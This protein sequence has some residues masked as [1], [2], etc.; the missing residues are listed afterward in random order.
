MGVEECWR[1]CC[2]WL[3]KIRLIRDDHL[4][5]SPNA[6]LIDLCKFLRDGVMICKILHILDEDSIDLRTINQR[7]Q[8][9]QFLCMKNIGIF[10]QTCTRKFD[11]N[12]E[13]LFE[14]PMLFE[15]SDIGK[16]LHTLSRLSKSA[17]AQRLEVEG[18]PAEQDGRDDDDIY[19]ELPRDIMN[20]NVETSNASPM[21]SNENDVVRYG[22][23]HTALG[24]PLRRR[25]NS[26][27]AVYESLCYVTLKPKEVVPVNKPREKRDLC[28]EE[29]VETEHN[30]VDA[31]EMLTNQFYRPLREVIGEE[32]CKRIF[33]TIPKM[34]RIHKILHQGL[35]KAQN[36]PANYSVS[37]V[38][39]TNQEE[40]LIY[41]EY[42]ANLSIAQQEL[43]D[44]MNNNDSAKN[45]IQELQNNVKEGKHQLREYLLVPLQR[46]LKYHLLL[47]ELIRSTSQTHSDHDNLQRA[48]EAMM[49]LSDFI[50]EVKR[51]S[52]MKQIIKDLQ[53]SIMD[54]PSEISNMEDLGKLRHDGDIRIECHPHPIKKRY[55]FVFD[56]VMIMCKQTKRISQLFANN[57]P[58][59]WSLG[60]STTEDEKYVFKDWV[61]LDCCKVDNNV[62]GGG[63]ITKN[64]QNSFYLVLGENKAAYT[65]ITKDSDAK[66]KWMKSISEAIEFLN[67]PENLSLHHVFIV[68]TFPRPNTRC[69]K[70]NKLLKGSIFQG[71]QCANCKMIVHKNC[72]GE[73]TRC[74]GCPPPPLIDRGP[75]N[76]VYPGYLNLLLEY[77]WWAD[78][79]SRDNAEHLLSK[80]EE[81]TFL[82]RWSD[83]HRKPVLSLRA[84]GETKHM[85]VHY[86]MESN[87]FFLSEAHYFSSIPDLI[88]FH[89]YSPLSESFIGLDC[90]LRRP[91]YD[92]A[93]VQYPYEGSSRTY[94]S[95]ME[96]ERVIILSREGE[97]RGWWKGRIGNR[98]GYF[99]KEYV[100]TDPIM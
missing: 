2:E 6:Q 80:A 27:E 37:Q 85:K 18:F 50:N 21:A 68:T 10:L 28:L 94:L 77:P 96:G 15:L 92:T 3:S 41:G 97:S 72:L 57:N 46:I 4:L 23:D 11:L 100:R 81:E 30:Y 12:K 33:S 83:R 61:S 56:K 66:E 62:T 95:L 24:F 67:P 75:L 26:E 54:M 14:P 89:S 5:R 17:K 98:M 88:N 84:N 82:L 19:S 7:P 64:K 16:V 65:I 49:D 76:D 74:Q 1:E 48:H 39:L 71:Y 60:D 55:V 29:L 87:H 86:I 34:V 38:F 45:K 93:T 35:K 32:Q 8:N 43:E 9:A 47:R 70:C 58:N 25:H 20:H 63:G 31:L 40:L 78:R 91:I 90:V 13:D 51:D 42:C 52:E 53:N 99:P 69:E 73:V 22:S 44:L 36:N 79:M 59:R